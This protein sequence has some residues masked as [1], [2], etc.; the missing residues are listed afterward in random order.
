MV[1]KCRT[2]NGLVGPVSNPRGEKGDLSLY[3][4]FLIKV[5]NYQSQ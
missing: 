2:L 4:D 1:G 3:D 5:L